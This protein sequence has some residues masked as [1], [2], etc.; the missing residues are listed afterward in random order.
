MVFN[1]PFNNILKEVSWRLILLVDITGVSAE[2][3]QL[4]ANHWQNLSHNAASST[5]KEDIFY[6]KCNFSRKIKNCRKIIF[7]QVT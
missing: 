5:P 4:V 2:N 3:H 6:R 7:V 1:A